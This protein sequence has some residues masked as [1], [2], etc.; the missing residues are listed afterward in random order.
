[1]PADSLF[2]KI[3]RLTKKG[4][5]IAIRLLLDEG[6]DPNLT[7]RFGWTLLMLAALHGRTDVA[8]LLVSRGADPTKVNK[9]GDSPDSL[10]KCKGYRHFASALRKLRTPARRNKAGLTIRQSERARNP[11]AQLYVR[12]HLLAL[13]GDS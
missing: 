2:N 13:L 1:M 7:N 9:F 11:V 3:H 4:D 5:I 8:D 10:A 12:F 6:L